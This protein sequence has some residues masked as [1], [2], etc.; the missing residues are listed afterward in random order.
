MINQY[1]VLATKYNNSSYKLWHNYAMFNYQY[2][3]LIYS[4]LKKNE[5]KNNSEKL[6]K[7]EVL[8]AINAVNGFK[9][10]LSIGGKNRNKTSQDLLRL[11]DIFF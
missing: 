5:I 10:S 8:Y 6:N 1:F 4:Y 3:K 7:K 2:Y 9:H 11:I